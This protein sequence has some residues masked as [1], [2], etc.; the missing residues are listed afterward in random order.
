M[1]LENRE[2]LNEIAVEWNLTQE[3]KD[4]FSRYIELIEKWST[5]TNLV[6]K[7]DVKKIAIR[8]IKESLA[9]GRNAL[10]FENKTVLDLGTGA[11]LPGIPV[12]ILNPAIYITLLDSKRIKTLF[13]Q[14]VIEQLKLTQITVVCDRV[15]NYSLKDNRPDYDIVISRAVARL[16]TLWQWSSTLLVEKGKLVV[17]KGGNIDD[18]LE[19]LNQKFSDCSVQVKPLYMDTFDNEKDKKIL[20]VER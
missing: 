18:E 15:E 20:I 13:L 1:F 7:G 16:A 3:Q 14:E 11:G 2:S 8:H 10:S 9:F 4:L 5:R 19:E 12:R 17:I 6:S